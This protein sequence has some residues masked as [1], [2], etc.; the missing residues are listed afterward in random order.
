[1]LQSLHYRILLLSGMV[2]FSA[3]AIGQPSNDNCQNAFHLQIAPDEASCQLISATTVNATPS[4]FPNNVCSGISFADDVWFS[5]T[6]GSP[7]A[8]GAVIIRCYFSEPFADVPSVGM[9]VYESCNFSAQP[10]DCFST[11]DPERNEIVLFSGSLIPDQTY[12][13]RVWSTPGMNENSGTFRICAFRQAPSDDVVLWGDDPGEGDFD[14]GMNGWTSVA[15]SPP[16]TAH[17]RWTGCSCSAGELDHSVLSSPTA[18]NGAMI[19]DADSLNC[20]LSNDP[21][22]LIVQQTGELWSPIIDCSAFPAVALKFYQSYAAVTSAT[23]I[24]YS[25]DGGTSWEDPIE[26]NKDIGP[27]ERTYSPSFLRIPL[28]AAAGQSQF[29]FKFIFSGNFYSWIIDDVQLVLLENND[30]EL[31]KRSVAIAPNAQWPVSQLECFGFQGNVSNLGAATQ[32]NVSFN[33]NISDQATS[34]QVYEESENLGNIAPQTTLE[35]QVIEGCFTPENSIAAYS[36]VYSVDSDSTDHSPETNFATFDFNVTETVFAKETGGTTTFNPGFFA[37][38][39]G[40]PH[41]WAF[42]N[43]FHIVK[44]SEGGEPEVFAR[45]GTFSIGNAGDNNVAGKVLNLILY[46]WN[47]DSNNDGNMDPEERTKIAYADYTIV[48]NEKPLDLITLPLISYPD[49]DPE[50]PEPVVLES[51]RDYVLMLEYSTTTTT[52]IEFVV[53]TA[54]NYSAQVA[55]SIQNGTPRYAAMFGANGSLDTTAYQSASPGLNN[56]PVVR[57]HLLDST[58]GTKE[59]VSNDLSLILSPNPANG[60]LRVDIKTQ[61]AF[62]EAAIK[63]Y[64]L[65]GRLMME[66][67]IENLLSQTLNFDVSGLTSGAYFLQFISAKA[68]KTERFIIQR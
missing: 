6:T 60:Q 62:R 21:P 49:G 58:I 47:D 61:E 45:S 10:L 39:I 41:S 64:D 20:C 30:L 33:I 68:I 27:T 1:M 13:V 51:N 4:A 23:Y 40:E 37:W 50:N 5:F 24:A 66:R 28:P 12:Y 54:Y 9:A 67:P 18:H 22:P 31:T 55:L 2:F 48:G 63:I 8:E 29:R 16:D 56:V 11:A 35:N 26:V 38:D 52:D 43:F 19:F 59:V 25:T 53:S 7:V 32:P 14:G 34:D 3:V 57:L 46:K 42:G 17:W 15:I 36:G 65:N 44:G